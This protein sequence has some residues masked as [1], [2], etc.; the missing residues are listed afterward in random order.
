MVVVPLLRRVATRCAIALAAGIASLSL[1]AETNVAPA[2]VAPLAISFFIDRRLP[3]DVR[4]SLDE[5]LRRLSD[6]RCQE[7][8]TDFSDLS[9]RRL[10]RNLEAIGQS[11]PGYLA[12]VLFYDGRY[13]KTCA[14]RDVLA[15]TSP[16]SRAVQICWNQFSAHQRWDTGYTANIII[17]EALHTL[18]LGEG[19]PDARAITAKVAERC[20]R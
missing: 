1:H 11:A 7:V 2:G 8:F 15:W 6:S 17:H 16:G 4:P 3:S 19:P 5:A 10:D 20:G 13:T 12:L 9:G 14:R 18:G